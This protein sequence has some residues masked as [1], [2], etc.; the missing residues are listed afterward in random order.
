MADERW[1]QSYN[2][3]TRRTRR[4]APANDPPPIPRWPGPHVGPPRVDPG[5]APGGWVV[6]V[7]EADG[8]LITARHLTPGMDLEADASAAVAMLP[9]SP[10]GTPVLLV[11]FDG[12][13]GERA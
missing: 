8:T 4:P 3:E 9:G 7:Y 12:D 6:H 11:M 1:R 2:D 13:T 10:A 5:L